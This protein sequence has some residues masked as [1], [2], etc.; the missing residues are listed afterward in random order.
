MNENNISI[1]GGDLRNIRLAKILKDD[2]FDVYTY[3]LENA[4]DIQDDKE[5]YMCDSIEEALNKSCIIISAIPFSKD[6]VFIN[7]PF[8]EKEIKI[9][10]LLACENGKEKMLFTG[11]LKTEVENELISCFGKV[12]DVMKSEKLTILNT[13]ATAEGTIK[14][15][16]EEREKNL[17]ESSVLVLGFGR[18]A[19]VVAQKFKAL[20]TN[21]TCAARKESDLAWIR[22]YGYNTM[23]INF[24]DETLSDFD[25]IINTVP[26]VIV[27]K[28]QLKFMKKEVLIIDLASAPGGIDFNEA[29][30]Q[31]KKCIWALALPGKVA[32]IS[33]AEFIKDE[34][35]KSLEDNS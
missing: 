19:K 10:E 27:K 31:K 1:I 23:N 11:S 21:V 24:W 5:I 12:T 9:D 14:I 2:G 26:E 17:Q 32:P 22:T 29:K 20:G 28:S 3:G 4:N 30:K 35:Y 13:I 34:I 15:A 6:G 25:I 33:S 7:S 16:I 18:V 8:S